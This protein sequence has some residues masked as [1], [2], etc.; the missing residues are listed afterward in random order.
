MGFFNQYES[1][2][3]FRADFKSVSSVLFL[4][5]VLSFAKVLVYRSISSYLL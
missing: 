2:L 4:L 3:C 1:A 5:F